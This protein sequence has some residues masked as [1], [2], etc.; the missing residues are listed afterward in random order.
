MTPTMSQTGLRRTSIIWRWKISQVS[1][2]NFIGDTSFLAQRAAGL[3]Q[4]H[5]VEARPVQLDRGQPDAGTVEGAQD[6]R[7]G[8]G[9]RVDVEPQP[10]LGRLQ[11]PHVRLVAEQLGR[12]RCRTVDAHGHHV[13]G[14]LALEVVG[15]ALGDD[16]AV[17]HDGDPVAQRVGLFEVVRGDEDRHALA[18]QP[19]YLVPPVRAALRVE[20]GGRLV[21]EDD[22]RLVDDAER[23]VDPAALAARVGLALAVGELGELEA[24]DRAR[25]EFPGPGLGDPVEPGLQDQ[26]LA[27]GHGVPRAQSLGHVADPAADLTGGAAEVGTRDGGLP[28]VRHDQRGEHP[29][30][31]GLAGAVGAEEAEDLA[32]PH[33][34]V[35]A[36]DRV[37][38]PL[39]GTERLP[40]PARLDHRALL[41][42]LSRGDSNAICRVQSR[43]N[44]AR[45]IASYMQGACGSP[46]GSPEAASAPLA[47]R[48]ATRSHHSAS[49]SAL[50]IP[51]SM[52]SAM[53]AAYRMSSS[54][55]FGTRR[56][57]MTSRG[58]WAGGR[59]AAVL[60]SRGSAGRNANATANRSTAGLSSH[61][62][63]FSSAWKASSPL[64]V[65]SYV[66]RAG[67]APTCSV[68]T[69]RSRPS[70]ASFFNAW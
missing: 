27:C 57:S 24:S 23:H 59:S 55:P 49:A 16:L 14:H 19:P 26:L 54:L 34:E 25:G 61:Q 48:S 52:Y 1:R 32:F 47:S 56:P 41:P 43:L 63:R 36:T 8:G 67:R 69:S 18:A 29:Q 39:P 50:T 60:S 65:I 22:L 40:Q 35:D 37:H 46:S 4:E 53:C 62:P 38:G 9:S 5:V 2:R 70:S 10:V 3:G 45:C 7:D 20:A 68:V 30:G 44:I 15:R 28:A 51:S 33:P 66:V 21:E 17:I 12:A 58:C 11:L 13:A 31:G 64:G 42:R 6:V